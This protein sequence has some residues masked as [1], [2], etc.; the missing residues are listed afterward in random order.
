MK[1]INKNLLLLLVSWIIFLFFLITILPWVSSLSQGAGLLDS[2]DTNFSFNASTIYS[3]IKSYGDEGR[4]FYIIQRWTFDLIWPIVYAI[5]LYLTLIRF[6]ISNWKYLPLSAMGFD[7]VENI[8]FTIL[9][10]L[11][12]TRIEWLASI[13]VLISL[14]K[15][16]TLSLSMVLAILLPLWFLIVKLF[17]SRKY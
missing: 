8:I 2:I 6:P 5:P 16:I 9:V 4:I 12:P 3:I 7:Y 10:I 1:K 13:G 17:G 11:F 15:W 14:V